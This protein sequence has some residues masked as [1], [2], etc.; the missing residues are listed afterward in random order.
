MKFI[1]LRILL[2]PILILVI[3]ATWYISKTLSLAKP[4]PYF[5][6]NSI[7]KDSLTTLGII[8]DSWVANNRLDNVLHKELTKQGFNCKIISS[9]QPSARSKVIY[10]N[11]FK[12]ADVKYSSRYIIEAKPE[13]CLIVAG[14]NDISAQ[15]GKRYYSFHIVQIIK[16]LLH[17]NIRPILISLPEFDIETTINKMTPALKTRNFILEKVNNGNREN[18]IALYREFLSS[19]LTKQNLIDSILIIDFDKVCSDY[20]QCK[21]YYKDSAHLSAI[22]NQKLCEI[23]VDEMKKLSLSKN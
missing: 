18:S 3:S 22:G 5:S 21:N 6:V 14:V 11:L 7:K 12:G 20:S 1:K 13:Y 10:Q 19:K 16:T 9:G 23:I 8:G 15:I 4:I 17:Y 2:I